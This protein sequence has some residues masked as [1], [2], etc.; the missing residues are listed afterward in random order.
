[1]KCAIDCGTICFNR[2]QEII[3][4]NKKYEEYVLIQIYRK[5][6]T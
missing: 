2:N 3:E 4:W 1:M 6:N 5:N